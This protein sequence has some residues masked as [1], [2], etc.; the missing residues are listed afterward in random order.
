M[1]IDPYVARLKRQDWL[2]KGPLVEQVPLFI[3]TLRRK[4][5]RLSTSLSYLKC[6]AHFGYWMQQEGMAARDINQLSVTRFIKE[7][8]STCDCPQPCSSSVTAN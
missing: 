1:L 8:L 6:V 2:T 3:E 5:Y 4:R 7:H